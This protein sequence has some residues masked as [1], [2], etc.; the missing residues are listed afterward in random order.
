MSFEL[1]EYVWDR[2]WKSPA[3]V[4]AFKEENERYT[5][6]EIVSSQQK[7]GRVAK[8]VESDIC[9][10]V[11]LIVPEDEAELAE[12][13]VGFGVGEHMTKMERELAD[14]FANRVLGAR[15]RRGI[16]QKA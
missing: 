4:V 8:R 9:R 14:D 3:M 12:R 10:Y 11:K 2:V 15:Q 1:R 16:V 6:V 7:Y 5:V 13:L